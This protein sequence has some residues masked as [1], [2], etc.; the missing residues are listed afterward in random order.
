[1]KN[2]RSGMQKTK[3]ESKN[4]KDVKELKLKEYRQRYYQR[5]REIILQK[6]AEKYKF[7]KLGMPQ[8]EYQTNQFKKWI[9][10]LNNKL[11]DETLSPMIRLWIKKQID[12][13]QNYER[14]EESNQED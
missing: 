7:K 6:A 11:N 2:Q 4:E 14:L 1:M 13:C 10:E 8:E 12:I 9:K 3:N 5:H